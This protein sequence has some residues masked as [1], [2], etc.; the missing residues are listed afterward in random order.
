MQGNPR[1]EISLL[2]TDDL[3]IHA[4][5]KAY[6]GID[7]PTDVLSFPLSEDDAL[8][9][10]VISMERAV[11][12]AAEYGH[13]FERELAFLV[14]HGMLHL[15]GMDHMTEDERRSMEKTQRQ[16]LAVMGLPR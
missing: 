16:I 12:Q 9:D 6:R 3:T 7:A 10:I 11:A 1:A 2:L 15:L 13:S 5:N 4:L 8:G 14:V